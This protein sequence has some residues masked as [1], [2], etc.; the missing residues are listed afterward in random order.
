MNG[1]VVD[2]NQALADGQSQAVA[3]GMSAPGFIDTEKS[4][5]EMCL[6]FC[7]YADA[8]IGYGEFCML[9][10]DASCNSHVAIFLSM[11]Q[12][13]ADEIGEYHSQ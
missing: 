6:S 4:F 5:K 11:T 2:F 7:W 12:R 1:A 8:I 10:N 3:T 13:I 9:I